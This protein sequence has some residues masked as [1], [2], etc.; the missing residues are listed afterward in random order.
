MAANEER[1]PIGVRPQPL[2]VEGATL[3]APS[4]H[5]SP[6]R[7]LALRGRRRATSYLAE[8]LILT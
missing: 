5:M 7:D 2:H 3:G 1:P 8:L 6:V 4:L